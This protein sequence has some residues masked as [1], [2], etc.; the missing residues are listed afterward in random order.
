MDWT[1]GRPEPWPVE[2]TKR[3]CSAYQNKKR[4]RLDNRRDSQ[5]AYRVSEGFGRWLGHHG[6]VTIKI[7]TAS[8]RRENTPLDDRSTFTSAAMSFGSVAPLVSRSTTKR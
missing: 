1:D 7:S 2:Y 8:H 3:D 6:L 5:L 4:G